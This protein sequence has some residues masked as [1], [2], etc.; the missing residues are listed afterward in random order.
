MPQSTLQNEHPIDSHTSNLEDATN[1]VYTTESKVKIVS[2]L[3]VIVKCIPVI[4]L[5]LYATG[6]FIRLSYF[7]SV[8]VHCIDFFRAEC[9]ETGA[10]FYVLSLAVLAS[11]FIPLAFILARRM[12]HPFIPEEMTLLGFI[13]SLSSVLIIWFTFLVT[14]I[15]LRPQDIGSIQKHLGQM[16]TAAI[17]LA[18]LLI[19]STKLHNRCTLAAKNNHPWPIN[20]RWVSNISDLIR[21]IFLLLVSYY[22]YKIFNNDLHKP[23]Y[24]FRDEYCLGYL[25][26]LALFCSMSYRLISTFFGDIGFRQELSLLEH[27][28]SCDKHVPKK[29]PKE[30]SIEK[31]LAVGL[32]VSIFFILF[33]LLLLSFTFG[34][35]IHIPTSRGGGSQYSTVEI[36]FANVNEASRYPFVKNDSSKTE[37][38]FLLEENSSWIYIVPISDKDSN[39]RDVFRSLAAGKTYCIKKELI[40]DMLFQKAK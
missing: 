22:A 2:R 37:G 14:T 1:S 26:F 36:Q 28:N 40:V 39:P 33:F 21:F 8:N 35:F 7:R 13:F 30:S 31:V 6:Y 12:K 27:R 5:I 25:L 38:V 15:F 4:V 10:T 3:D 24:V 16:T 11:L 29:S 23:V 32:R 18:V 17:G 20:S 9:F 19:V 34:P